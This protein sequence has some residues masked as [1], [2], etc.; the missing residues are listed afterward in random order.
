V[1]LKLHFLKKTLIYINKIV[2]RWSILYGNLNNIKQSALRRLEKLLY[3]RYRSDTI[4]SIEL[5]KIISDISSDIKRQIGLLLDRKNTIQYIIIGS[6]KNIIIPQLERFSVIPGKLRGLRLIHTHLYNEDLSKEDI[7]DLLYLRLDS[8]SAVLVNLRGLPYKITTAYI[9]PLNEKQ[10]ELLPQNDPYNIDINFVEFINEIEKSINKTKA[11]QNIYEIKALCIGV[12]ENKNIALDSLAELKELS[13]SAG[14]SIYNTFYQINKHHH[15]K[16]VIGKGKLKELI[17]DALQYGVN[18]LIFD[19]SLT[20]NQAKAI[21]QCTEMKIIDRNQLILD[22]FAKRAKSNDGKLR[23]ELAQLK[24]ILPRLSVKDDS[25]SR[26]TGGIGGRGPGETKLEIDR[27]R[28]YER[29]TLLTKKLKKIEQNRHVQRKKRS[30]ESLPIVS[31]VGYTNAGK[32]TLINSLTK[33]NNYADDKMFATLSPVSKRLRFPEEKEIIINDTVGF[34][35]DLPEDLKGAFK[36]TLEEIYD[37]WLIVQLVDASDSNYAKKIN[38][39]DLILEELSLNNIKRLLVFNKIDLLEQSTI[40]FLKE[41]YKNALFISAYDTKTFKP[42][43][44]NIFYTIF[45]SKNINNND[46][47]NVL[48]Y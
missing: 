43:L 2:K 39:V 8:I 40:K 3:K 11:I 48:N 35:K 41:T 28:V 37:S 32:S 42:L 19:N 13:N 46:N 22:I 21:S 38:S 36:S 18:L 6:N 27:R 7:N 12:Y 45:L 14:I 10:W 24:Y 44:N 20:P 31:V 1:L 23:V 29:I 15:P 33:T 17:I 34:I 4:A 25:L 47:I 5:L 30:N 16:Y 26:L 9:S